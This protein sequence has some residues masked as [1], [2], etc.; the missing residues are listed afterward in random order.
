MR[1]QETVNPKWLEEYLGREKEPNDR[2]KKKTVREKSRQFFSRTY[3]NELL[4][5]HFH[6]L[7]S[8]FLRRFAAKAFAR[9]R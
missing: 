3:G 7:A 6:F 8:C 4:T 1:Q 9:Q 2:E 5:S